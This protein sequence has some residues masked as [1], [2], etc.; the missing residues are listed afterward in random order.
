MPAP[1]ELTNAQRLEHSDLGR[2]A[3]LPQGQAISHEALYRF[4]LILQSV[5]AQ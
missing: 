4:H 5:V 1:K 3:A 2:G